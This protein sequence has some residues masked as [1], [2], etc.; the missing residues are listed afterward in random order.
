MKQATTST[1]SGCI[2]WIFSIG[3]IMSCVLP[4]FIGIGTVTS[5][6]EFAI[7]TTGNVICPDGTTSESYSYETTTTDEFGNSQPATGVEL[8]CIDQGGTVVK[9]DPVVYAFLWD[10]IFAAAGLL[11]SILLAFAFAAPIGILIGRWFGRTQK[12]TIS[13]NLEPR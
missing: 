12:P 7:R 6:S 9:S 2:V 5:F 3:I 11:I 13:T 4:L 8:R 10:G 1:I